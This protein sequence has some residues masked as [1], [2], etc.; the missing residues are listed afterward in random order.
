MALALDSVV[1]FEWDSS[2][3]YYALEL[4]NSGREVY[5]VRS[6]G[7]I[8]YYPWAGSEL[9]WMI[10]DYDDSAFNGKTCFI[11]VE[12]ISGKNEERARQ[13]ER[14]LKQYILKM[15]EE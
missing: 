15:E 8:R 1:K 14:E 11:R 5:A 13:I 3:R 12:I 6:N 10:S 9:R 2:K 7:K 4:N